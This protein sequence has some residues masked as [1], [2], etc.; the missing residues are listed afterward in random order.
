MVKFGP[1]GNSDD[2][3]AQGFKSSEQ[4]PRWLSEMGLD[5]YEYSCTKGVKISD[6]KARMIGE[7][8]K[9]YGIGLSV[10]APYYIS[11]STD[12]EEKREKSINYILQTAHTADVMGADKIVV[13]SGACAK[14]PR[15]TALGYAEITLKKALER[16]K[17]EGLY[18]IH[19]CPETMGK[20]NQLGTI[21]EVLHL[22]RMDESFIPTIDF[23][24]LHTRGL[25]CLNNIT[26]FEKVLDMTENVLGKERAATFHAHFSRIE[27][28]VGGEKMHRTYEEIEYGP[29]F[30]PLAE[31]IYKRNISPTII[32]ESR[33]TMAKDAL[34]MKN[35]YLKFAN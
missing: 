26:D 29:D 4:M 14:M 21:E 2:F 24:H 8:A 35:I 15:E 22:C 11:L 25:G 13:H 10:H 34:T 20:V 16:L 7:Q 5:L 30:D 28:T 32:C 17:A 3:Y 33:G 27:Y 9:K 12:D 31:L 23:G 18:H 6:E 19:V 1:S